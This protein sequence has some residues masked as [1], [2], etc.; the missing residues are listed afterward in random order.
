MFKKNKNYLGVKRFKLLS[1][2]TKK[3]IIDYALYGGDDYE[4]LFS[5]DPINEE[6]L[7]TI[8]F[9]KNIKITKI[10]FFYESDEKKITFKNLDKK[11]KKVSF[12]HF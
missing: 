5:C 2:L 7:K 12:M 3:K 1:I 6:L 9:K 10:G 4:L 8:S 11:A